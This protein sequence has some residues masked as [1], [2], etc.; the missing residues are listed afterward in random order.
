MNQT[1]D[2]L[3][4]TI[5]PHAALAGASQL[6]AAFSHASALSFAILDDRLRYQTINDALASMTGIPAGAYIGNTKSDVL[7]NEF[8]RQVDPLLQRL[9][10]TGEP[11]DLEIKTTLPSRIEPCSFVC[12]YFAIKGSAGKV[13]GVG[14]AGV[15][16]TEQR[17]LDSYF[18]G[19]TSALVRKETRDAFWLAR[20][21]HDSVNEYHFALGKSIGRLAYMPEKSPE[22]LPQIVASLD[23]RILVM[24]KLLVSVASGFIGGCNAEP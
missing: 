17:K 24:R 13:V 8:A 2:L 11:L 20:E 9:L 1:A 4:D 12:H 14:T 10:V 5:A 7:G 22:L 21:L 16:V 3:P 18:K 15:E 23:Q 6:C 19:L